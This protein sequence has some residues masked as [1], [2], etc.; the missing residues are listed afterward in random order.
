MFQGGTSILFSVLIIL[1][2][3][4]VPVKSPFMCLDDIKLGL[5]C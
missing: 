4:S 2:S 3:V 1:V 5:G